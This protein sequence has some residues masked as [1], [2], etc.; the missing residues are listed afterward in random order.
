MLGV[1]TRELDNALV[2]VA[3]LHA[4]M[5]KFL[6]VSI[7]NSGEKNVFTSL[8]MARSQLNRKGKYHEKIWYVVRRCF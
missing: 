5:V 1:R 6:V 4:L 7:T 3:N 2:A 8:R